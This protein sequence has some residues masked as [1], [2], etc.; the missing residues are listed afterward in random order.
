MDVRA[1]TEAVSVP[2][3]VALHLLGGFQLFVD[4]RAVCI[5]ES[6]QRLLVFLALR[7][8]PQKRLLVAGSLWPEKSDDR[9]AANLRSALWRSRV[10]GAPPLVIGQGS[11]ISLSPLV[12][13]DARHM[14][15]TGWA[16]V[17]GQIASLVG[18]TVRELFFE[19]LLPGWYDDWVILER[20]RLNQLRLHFLEAL[21]AALLRGQR[22]AEALD[23]ALRLVAIDPLRER[24]QTTLLR[25]YEAEGSLH[26]ARQYRSACAKLGLTI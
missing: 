16:L 15:A 10:G 23:A 14:E 13:V 6:V 1:A 3:T 7:Q 5:T 19:D 4:Q 24:S 9:A 22:H 20:E 2:T 26:Q 21:I 11:L 25:V 12:E 18:G 8:R 17:K